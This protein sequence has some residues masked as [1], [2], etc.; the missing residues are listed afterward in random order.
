M[1]QSLNLK[2]KVAGLEV[3]TFQVGKAQ[4]YVDNLKAQ[5][6]QVAEV[7]SLGNVKW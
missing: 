4:M 1:S 6:D 2:L 5:V 7:A 3:E